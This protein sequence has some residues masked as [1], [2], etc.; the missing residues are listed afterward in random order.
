[1]YSYVIKDCGDRGK[2]IVRDDG[3]SMAAIAIGNMDLHMFLCDWRDGAIVKDDS[4]I[5]QPYSEAAVEVL[6]LTPVPAE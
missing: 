5:D 6:G 3:L 1:M 4:G 2:S